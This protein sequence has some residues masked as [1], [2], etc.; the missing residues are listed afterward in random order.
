MDVLMCCY[1]DPA[2]QE[3]C[4]QDGEFELTDELDRSET[5]VTHT[6]TQH[7]GPMLGH[8]PSIEVNGTQE[9]RVRALTA[10]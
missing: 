3:P 5:A 8:H 4:D 9:W 1:I 7:V 6:C 10:S 2:T